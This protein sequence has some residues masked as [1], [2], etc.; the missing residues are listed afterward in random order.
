MN[1]LDLNIDNYNLKDLLKLFN[2]SDKFTET[3]MKTAKKIVLKTH[4]DKSGLD[5]KYFLFFSKAYKIIYGIYEFRQNSKEK[6][7]EYKP[8]DDNEN[9]EIIKNALNSK[10]LQKDFN[11][12]F[13]ELFEKTKIEDDFSKNGYENWLRSNEDIDNFNGLSKLEQEK[14]LEEKKKKIQSLVIHKDIDEIQKNN[15]NLLGEKPNDYSS[16]LFSSLAYEDLKKA[17][18]E[19]IIPITNNDLNNINN[20]NLSQLKSERDKQIILPSIEQAKRLLDERN[21]KNNKYNAERAFNL[22]KEDE[23]IRK[24]NE[25][26]LSSIRQLR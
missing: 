7:T 9:K 16:D 1:N 25:L 26:C 19:S 24:A 13:N 8:I 23:K 17:H 6:D 15:Y 4:P 14:K 21:N 2:I 11:K 5:Q 20:K 22:I 18:Q 12:W 10:T 3:E